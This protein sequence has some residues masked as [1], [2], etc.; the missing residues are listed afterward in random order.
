MTSYGVLQLV[1]YMVV[2]LAAA[3][4]LGIFMAASM[5]AL[6]QVYAIDGVSELESLWCQWRCPSCATRLAPA[7]CKS[8]Q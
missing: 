8:A 2:L 5:T 3:W 1:F 6:R 7:R 4:P